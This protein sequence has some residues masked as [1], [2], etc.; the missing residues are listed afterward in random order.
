MSEKHQ[1]LSRVAKDLSI[2]FHAE[3][4]HVQLLKFDDFKWSKCLIIDC[5]EKVTKTET[6]Y[7][8]MISSDLTNNKS[9]T[10]GI[11]QGW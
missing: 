3:N 4:N 9:N 10:G 6:A 11:V 1:L 8:V 2:D 5:I 7:V